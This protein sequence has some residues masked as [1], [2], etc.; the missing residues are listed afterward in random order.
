MSSEPI[1][2]RY[3]RL[4][5]PD[6]RADIDDELEFHIGERARELVAGGLDR[7]AASARARAEFGNVARARE[8]CRTIREED[9]TRT[10]RARRLA[11]L[12]QDIRYAIRSAV[13]HP[14]HAVLV[15]VT[16]A[17]GLGATTA[18]LSVVNGVLLRPLPYA[19]PGRL[20]RIH[21]WS[22][23]GDDHNPVS[24]G[25][26]LDWKARATS[27]AVMGAHYHAYPVTF[28]GSG[29]PSR[30][31]VVDATP[32]VLA[33]LGANPRIGRLFTEQDA[34]GDQRVLVIS[35][36]LWRG[37]FGADSAILSRRLVL[38]GQPWTILGVMPPEFTY[39][40]ATVTMWRLQSESVFTRENR[41]SHNLQVVARLR[42][43][44]TFTQ[45]K[46]E[47]D[48]IA[49][50]LGLEYPQFMADWRVNV[51]PM[52]AD[53]VAPVRPL[54]VVLLAGAA[55]LLVVA[56]GNA[57]NLLLTRA[58][59]RS[60]EI[61]VRGALG[62]GGFR[63]VR[64]LL[65]ESLLLALMAAAA[66]AGV[67]AV[68]LRALVALAP[69][70]LPRLD[71][72]RLDPIVLAWSVLIAALSTI[73][74]GLAPAIRLA[75]VDLQSTLRAA[76]SRGERHGRLRSAL[77][78]MEVA[79]SLVML[80]GAGLL[81]R[82][83]DR[84]RR[85]D[86]GFEPRGLLAVSLS[87]PRSRYPDAPAQFE[88]YRRLQERLGSFPGVRVATGTSD[89]PANPT[90]MTFSF[91]IQGREAPN[92]SGRFDPVPLHAV[93]PGYFATLG[94]PLIRGRLFDTRDRTGAAPVAI[95]NQALAR[96]FWGAD[97]PVGGR[98]A[99]SGPDGP[100][101]EV[102]GVVGDTRIAGAD[103]EPPPVIYVPYLQKTWPW[104]N[105]Q[106]ALLRL[107]PDADLAATAVS[108]RRVLTELDPDLAISRLAPVEALYAE[109]QARRRLAAVL[110]GGF[111]GAALLLG[112]IGLYGVMS[113]V[114]AERQQEIGVRMALGAG[115]AVVLG[116]VLAQ[117]A[118]LVLAGVA[119]G[120][121][122]AAASTKVLTALLYE[123]SPLDPLTF[124]A[125]ALLL[126]LAGLGAALI[127]ARRATAI[128]PVSAIR[129]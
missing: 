90:P 53:I 62:A 78:I 94:V 11:D 37:R 122:V 38:D 82:S 93:M 75:R 99:F 110:L 86:Y 128:D 5:R 8:E 15:T 36:A 123:T 23:Q 12:G 89:A 22:P 32:S 125:V 73:V 28:T 87:L 104:L 9:V 112:V 26:Y 55:L 121:L 70:D 126:V 120:A 19:A 79:A 50:A 13:R 18:I 88:F 14:A 63:L 92:P 74:V 100:W 109:G 39:P 1:W 57:G 24:V 65:V 31:V 98:I 83:F 113:T 40:D 66:G 16:L 102:V 67:A 72:V 52:H 2:R 105:W 81:A 6:A 91:A 77:V 60:R 47:M 56:C 111:A 27:F 119:V 103:A 33:V 97:D 107:P 61:A 59:A 44:A 108:I 96:L 80:I 51:A 84:L 69:A 42:D 129:E 41:R 54:I 95:V 127:P 34:P 118:G 49:T 117:A 71:Q 20:A 7:E 114:V 68:A 17:L 115:R 35:D 4:L 116:M 10:T 21:E 45:A 30:L 46:A 3:A 124:G 64:Q 43:G 29:D 101:L 25:N 76:H 48:V 58:L 85:V 106:T